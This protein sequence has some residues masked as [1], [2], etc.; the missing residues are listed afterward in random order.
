MKKIPAIIPARGGSKRLLRKNILPFCGY[1]LVAWSIVQCKYCK[2]ID[3]V[4]VT[5]DD[6]EIAEISE[7]W[8][9]KVIRRP[10]WPNPDELSAY[11]PTQHAI[12]QIRNY[13]DFDIHTT[14][15]P[16]DPVWHPWDWD[17]AFERWFEIEKKNPNIRVLAPYCKQR[18]VNVFRILYDDYVIPMIASKNFEYVTMGPSRPILS[19]RKAYIKSIE[20]L[21]TGEMRTTDTVE[22]FGQH[23]GFLKGLTNYYLCEW[24]Q[25]TSIDDQDS[26]ELNE[27]FMERYVLKGRDISI[28]QEYAE[29][30]D[31]K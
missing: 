4:W 31:A 24:Y 25:G 23:Q 17:R 8:G 21:K 16:T 30:G 11:M 18:E 7:R 20:G 29:R 10:D 1:P 26:F 9:A 19:T 13:Y 12:E 5:T 28:Y 3:D 15:I 27:I 22:G 14:A 2:Y 6:D